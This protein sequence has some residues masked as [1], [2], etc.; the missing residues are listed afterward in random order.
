MWNEQGKKP[1]LGYILLTFLIAWICEAILIFGEQFAILTGTVGV[2][3]TFIIMGFGVGLAPMYAVYILLK[4]HKR[5][6][7][8]KDFF[9]R[10]FKVDNVPKTII[11]TTVF[12]LI[13]IIPN[14][15]F[16][17]Y[18]GNPWYLFIAYIPLMIIG[19]GL[20]EFGWRGFLQPAMNEKL[21]FIVTSACV[22]VIWAVWHLPLWFMKNTSQSSMN[23]IAF[24]CFCIA[25]AFTLATLYKLTRSVFACV[26]LHAW[27]N[28]LGGMFTR[29][30]FE[31]PVDLKL[32]AVYL[33]QIG[34]AILVFYI[35]DK[36][37]KL[38]L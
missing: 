6:R 35:A 2:V 21:P 15:M 12:C 5:I 13:L 7:G 34:A 1:I 11:I 29:D 3:V 22:G 27:A 10:V 30:I 28:V 25:A 17:S 16:N 20:E 23:F 26:F 14:I 18:L 37:V 32:L 38:R 36:K 24:F 31:N 9:G 4:K 19:G 8:L 33:I